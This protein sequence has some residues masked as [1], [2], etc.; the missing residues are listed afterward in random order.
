MTQK[1]T[2]GSSH[3]HSFPLLTFFKVLRHNRY[4]LSFFLH[5]PSHVIALELTLGRAPR[6]RDP[7]H[8]VLMKTLVPTFLINT[9]SNISSLNEAPPTIDRVSG[10]HKYSKA[11]E[12]MI[13]SCLLKD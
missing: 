9:F 6:S 1:P 5:S 8:K 3:T 10:L 13:S 4:H 7:P 2:S 12:D 11:F